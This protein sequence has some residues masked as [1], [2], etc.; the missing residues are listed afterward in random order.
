[1]SKRETVAQ[2]YERGRLEGLQ[3]GRA[4]TEKR[5]EVRKHQLEALEAVTRL[6]SQAG[7]A[8]NALSNVYDNGPS[9]IPTMMRN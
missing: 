2:A 8:I 7:Q 5:L 4:E 9:Q 3:R 1:M 6:V